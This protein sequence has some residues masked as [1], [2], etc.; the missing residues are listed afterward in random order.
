MCSVFGDPQNGCGFS[1]DFASKQPQK[2][3][4]NSKG[5]QTQPYGGK[6][7]FTRLI[8]LRAPANGLEETAGGGDPFS[9][10][11]FQQPGGLG[12]LRLGIEQVSTRTQRFGLEMSPTALLEVMPHV[13]S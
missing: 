7:R 1:L 2:V 13:S 6:R 9:L 11:A 8:F 12:V 10:R 5:R 3:G 4:T